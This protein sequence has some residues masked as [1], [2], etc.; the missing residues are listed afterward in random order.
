MPETELAELRTVL[1]LDEYHVS[2]RQEATSSC[3]LCSAV[4][5]LISSPLALLAPSDSWLHAVQQLPIRTMLD[6]W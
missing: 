3:A 1:L 4:L 5:F 2:H 6:G